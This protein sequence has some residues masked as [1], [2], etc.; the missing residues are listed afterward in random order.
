MESLYTPEKIDIGTT[1]AEE[2]ADEALKVAKSVISRDKEAVRII[3]IV[4][5]YLRANKRIIYGGAAA[6]ALMPKEYKFYDPIYDL[7]D[8]D[9]LTPDGL[10]D[11]ANLI[12]KYKSAGFKDVEARLGI[13]EGTYK[14]FVNFRPA[15][16]ITEIP[17]DLYLRLQNKSRIRNGLL[18]A[19]P[20]WLR[21][22]WYLEL[23]RPM[24]DADRWR[25]IFKRLQYLNKVYP[26]KV[27]DD[28]TK[29]DETK[30]RFPP[31]KRRRLHGIILQVVAD[32]R[33]FFIGAMVESVYK[34]LIEHRDTA[35]TLIGSSL[36]KYNP[37][38]VLTTETLE[39]T[40]NYLAAELKAAYP[41]TLVE[42]K[43][44]VS[45]GDVVP[46]RN[47]VY[48]GKR[49]VATIFPTVAC[50]AFLTLNI[51]LPYD[52]VKY[53]V[54][55]A[56]I[57]SAITILYEMW[58]TGLQNSVGRR[59]LCL[60][61]TLVEIEAHMRLDNPKE[62]KISL[63]P[64]T[65]I[66]HQPSLPELKKSHRARVHAKKEEVRKYLETK[67]LSKTRKIKKI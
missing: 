23:S 3:S 20:D 59:I 28:T 61:Q 32:T 5:E 15:A 67:L 43:P 24:G 4:E 47:E 11:C 22:S 17:M 50:H 30:T 42:I 66:G 64:F 46:Q 58:F 1:V 45:I 60:L 14:V 9:F 7:P 44:Y 37:L 19:P 40:T 52:P 36:V 33:T 8:Y 16:D 25:K 2:Y 39:E 51:H 10:E 65:C 26:L 13:H 12:E 29:V 62:S 63:F 57:D 34:A 38:Y 27:C 21:M 53:L 54:R 35:E 18:C 48:F 6:N 49:R 56:S 31:A 41:A 55:V